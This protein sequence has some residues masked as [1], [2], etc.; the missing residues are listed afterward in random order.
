MIAEE[1]TSFTG[2]THPLEW[3]GLGF[4]LK[5]NM[6]WMN[7][8]LRY[9]HKDPL[10]RHYHQ[11]DLTFGLLYAFSERFILR[12]SH[13]EVVHGKGSLLCQN[14]GGRLA[15][16]CQLAAALQL[17]DL[18]AGK[19][20]AFHGRGDRAVGRVE[21][22]RGAPLGSLA[23]TIATTMLQSFVQEINHFYHAQPALWEYDFDR[24]RI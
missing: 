6:G 21:L 23:A 9:F 11:N 13:D 15:E 18:P 20:T 5:W 19:K 14:A 10:F 1:S 12:L 16:I 2:V 8:T 7:D 22:Q 3:G 24:Q 17:S 4:D